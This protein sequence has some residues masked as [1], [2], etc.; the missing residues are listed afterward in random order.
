MIELHAFNR[1][2]GLPNRFPFSATYLCSMHVSRWRRIY[3]PFCIFSG[4]PSSFN[5]AILRQSISF[6]LFLL[7]YFHFFFIFFHFWSSHDCQS[8]SARFNRPHLDHY[9]LIEYCTFCS[10]L[11]VHITLPRSCV[12]RNC[13][14]SIWVFFLLFFVLTSFALASFDRIRLLNLDAFAVLCL[15]IAPISPYS[16][17]T[18]STCSCLVPAWSLPGSSLLLP[19]GNWCSLRLSSQHFRLVN[20]ELAALARPFVILIRLSRRR[21]TFNFVCSRLFVSLEQIWRLNRSRPT[22]SLLRF[23][24]SL[25]FFAPIITFIVVPFAPS[26]ETCFFL[27]VPFTMHCH[28]FALSHTIWFDLELVRFQAKKQQQR[29]LCN[30]PR[31]FLLRIVLRSILTITT[32]IRLL[33]TWRLSFSL[34]LF[35][36]KYLSNHNSIR[37]CFA[38]VHLIS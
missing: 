11:S 20:R 14:Q 17:I 22:L 16:V 2:S 18:C 24:E 38:F 30:S 19:D 6:R 5:F 9:S 8:A 1:I 15:Q 25:Q 4:L 21:F 10:F 29:I 3:T 28:H 27:R 26:F 31:P 35:A 32:S 23:H 34:L 37:I 7:I 12:V 36:A 33:T 13:S